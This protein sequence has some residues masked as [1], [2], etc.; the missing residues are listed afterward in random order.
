MKSSLLAEISAKLE[1][2]RKLKL[3][4]YALAAALAALLFLTSGVFG[5]CR[6]GAKEVSSVRPEASSGEAEQL[7]KKLEAILSGMAGV[8]RARVML[9][10]ERTGEQVIAR[11]EKRTE[12]SGGTG[13]ESRP[14]T[15]N[16]G[17]REEAIVLTERLPEVR[18]VIVIAEGAGN[19]AVRLNISAAV[20]TV[21]GIDE[22]RVDVFVM[23]GGAFE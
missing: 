18:G 15:V 3:M 11:D 21:L 4:V 5:S 6:S 20:S 12:G 17:G 19:I 22:E 2:N 23:A 16:S 14:A 10:L 1:K 13:T 9:T 7:E 8:G